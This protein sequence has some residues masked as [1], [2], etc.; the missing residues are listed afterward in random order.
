M[1][2]GDTVRVIVTAKV[3]EIYSDSFE[4][5]SEDG[6]EYFFEQLSGIEIEEVS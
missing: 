3:T 6:T 1:K 5:T 4:V 2:V